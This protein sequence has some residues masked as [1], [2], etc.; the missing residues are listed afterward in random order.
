MRTRNLA[1]AAIV[2][3]SV[4]ALSA[5]ASGGAGEGAMSPDR[6]AVVSQR[7]ATDE[8]MGHATVLQ[9]G[10]EEP[11]LCVGMLFQSLPPQC[12][13]PPI[14]GW[15]WAA[16][17]QEESASNVTWGDYV[18]YGTWDGNAFTATR[19]PIPSPLLGAP[20]AAARK[21]QHGRLLRVATAR[22][23]RAWQAPRLGGAAARPRPLP[24]ER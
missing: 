11:R 12:D 15:D 22:L 18:V 13:G 10:D 2:A 16:V 24:E 4:I 8:L 20:P 3:V 14:H 17:E 7:A 1:R 19:D 5:C 23:R 21:R 6:A 9:R